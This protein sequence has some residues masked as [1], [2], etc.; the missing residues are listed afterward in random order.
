MHV[1]ALNRCFENADPPSQM[2]AVLKRIIVVE[3]TLTDSFYNAGYTSP[4]WQWAQKFREQWPLDIDTS[5]LIATDHRPNH[6]NTNPPGYFWG[7]RNQTGKTIFGYP[8][9]EA[10][11]KVKYEF[12]SK[13]DSLATAQDIWL[14]FGL[15]HGWASYLCNLPEEYYQD[16]HDSK[17][18][19]QH[20]YFGGSSLYAPE[21]SAFLSLYTKEN[22]ARKNR[23]AYAES[24]RHDFSNYPKH[25]G[26]RIAPESTAA[27]VGNL[28][29]YR[30]LLKDGQVWAEE[31]TFSDTPEQTSTQDSLVFNGNL[32]IENSNC[33]LLKCNLKDGSTREVYVPSAPFNMSAA[34]G[35][36]IANYTIELIGQ[37]DPLK[38]VQAMD[39][40]TENKLQRHVENKTAAGGTLYAKAKVAGTDIWLLWFLQ[41]DP[42]RIL[43][44]TC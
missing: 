7:V 19:F 27:E 33:W 26:I 22:I 28:E 21:C 14:D 5:W 41:Q 20:F 11:Y 34:M 44:G 31:K 3:D 35:V 38:T 17:Q 10:E 32:F 13:D 40:V 18:R 15:I 43:L 25:I 6:A 9:G 2:R 23:D 30:V 42:K 36:Q 8:P 37:G 29:I 1:D 24:K 4:D 12:P 16:V 39:M